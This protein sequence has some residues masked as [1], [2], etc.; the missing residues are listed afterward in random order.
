[1][2]DLRLPLSD[3]F[4]DALAEAVAARLTAAHAEPEPWIGVPEAATHLAC[5]P[6]RIYDLVH[7]RAI[8]HRKDG[9]RLLFRRSELDGWLNGRA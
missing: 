4:V 2:T 5:K 1:M 7:A 6:Q 9:S 3:E 8:P